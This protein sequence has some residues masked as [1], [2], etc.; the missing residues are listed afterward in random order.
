MRFLPERPND[1]TKVREI[2]NA[3]TVSCCLVEDHLARTVCSPRRAAHAPATEA[4]LP[5]K[6]KRYPNQQTRPRA[7]HGLFV[8]PVML[9]QLHQVIISDSNRTPIIQIVVWFC[10][11]TAFLALVTHAGIKLFV[12]RAVKAES[13]L[14]LVSLVSS[15]THSARCNTVDCP[16]RCF[17]S[18]S[19]RLC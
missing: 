6:E 9:E 14:L 11:A 18:H 5:E 19:Q 2:S 13:V 16:P 1:I 7:L 8:A 15:K 4:L 17:A 10:L 12:F 3:E